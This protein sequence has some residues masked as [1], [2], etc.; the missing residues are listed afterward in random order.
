M[1]LW[2]E[3]TQAYCGY[4]S[5]LRRRLN[6]ISRCIGIATTRFMRCVGDNHQT[7]EEPCEGKAFM[8]GFVDQQGWVT[9]LLSLTT[10][11]IRN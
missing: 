8:H 7:V 9:A 11:S 2:S 10:L 1:E 6:G 4:S 5:I 3:M